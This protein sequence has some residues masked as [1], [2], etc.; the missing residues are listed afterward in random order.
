MKNKDKNN[1]E[2]IDMLSLSQYELCNYEGGILPLLGLV[3][4]A[5]GVGLAAAYG[6][7]YAIGSLTK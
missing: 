1:F 6:V 5:L 7:G 3:F 4:G 2:D